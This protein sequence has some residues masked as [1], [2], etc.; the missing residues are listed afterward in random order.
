MRRRALL[1]AAPSKAAFVGPSADVA[2]N[3]LI[4]LWLFGGL[5]PALAAVNVFAWQRLGEPQRYPGFVESAP[6]AKPAL[7]FASF[8]AADVVTEEDV[9]AIL[10]SVD[11][12]AFDYVPIAAALGAADDA[13][14]GSSAPSSKNLLY[15]NEATFKRR[16]RDRVRRRVGDAALDALFGAMAKGSGLASKDSVVA[17]FARWKRTDGTVNVASV[18]RDA[19][20]GRLTTLAGFA[21]L[22]AIDLVAL[23]AL[24]L[25]AQRALQ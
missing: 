10:S 2:K 14:L 22:A 7:Q 24:V 1:M 18:D 6:S 19:L 3:A 4:S 11:V 16:C 5:L 23:S 20:L 9:E 8:G 12:D 15:L 21:G 13:R 25:G 17:T